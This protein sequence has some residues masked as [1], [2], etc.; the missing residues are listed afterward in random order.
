MNEHSLKK[1]IKDEM[2][3]HIT[4]TPPVIDFKQVSSLRQKSSKPSLNSYEKFKIN[5]C[6]TTYDNRD[7]NNHYFKFTQYNWSD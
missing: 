4:M 2:D 1:V 5:I 7:C 3:K 6:I